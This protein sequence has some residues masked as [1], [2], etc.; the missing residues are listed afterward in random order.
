[1]LFALPGGAL[2]RRHFALKPQRP[3]KDGGR[4][5]TSVKCGAEFT[6]WLNNVPQSYTGTANLLQVATSGSYSPQ[7]LVRQGLLV[8]QVEFRRIRLSFFIWAIPNKK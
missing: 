3:A 1:M 7:S 8:G 6:N 4:G 2:F 5:L